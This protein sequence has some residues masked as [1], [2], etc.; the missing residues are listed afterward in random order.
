MTLVAH[1]EIGS[2][3]RCSSIWSRAGRVL[4]NFVVQPHPNRRIARAP[5]DAL[6]PLSIRP[7]TLPEVS[8]ILGPSTPHFH[9]TFLTPARLQILETHLSRGLSIVLEDIRTH[10]PEILNPAFHRVALYPIE[11]LE[12]LLPKGNIVICADLALIPQS[13]FILRILGGALCLSPWTS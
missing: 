8:S 4:C 12:L 13:G 9:F 3:K 2:K 1:P 6:P 5:R 11:T 7:G 10:G